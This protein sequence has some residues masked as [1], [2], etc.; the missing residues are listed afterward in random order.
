MSGYKSSQI[1]LTR[2]IDAVNP[3]PCFQDSYFD[4]GTH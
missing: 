1:K 2:Y 4:C 3:D